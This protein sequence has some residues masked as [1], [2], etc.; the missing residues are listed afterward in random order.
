MQPDLAVLDPGER[1]A[2]LHPPLPEG[3]DLATDQDDPGLVG[4]QDV[5]VVA[6]STV[7][8]HQCP[9]GSSFSSHRDL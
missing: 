8:G 6:R 1:V 5:V 3:L 2:Q 4:V 9:T 7:L